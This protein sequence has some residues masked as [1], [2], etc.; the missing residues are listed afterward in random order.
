MFA[1]LNRAPR[2]EEAE[3]RGRERDRAVPVRPLRVG[4]ER[5]TLDVP[6]PLPERESVFDELVE[7]RLLRGSI[8][9]EER[10]V[11]AAAQHPAVAPDLVLDARI[12][13]HAAAIRARR[14]GQ[15][16][17]RSPELHLLEVEVISAE[18]VLR[19]E[20]IRLVR[21]VRGPSA[22]RGGVA[23][24]VDDAR[25]RQDGGVNAVVV[26]EPELGVGVNQRGSPT[27][28]R[29]CLR[30]NLVVAS[31]SRQCSGHAAGEIGLLEGDGP[32]PRV[33]GTKPQR[34]PS[35]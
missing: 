22:E 4:R 21:P 20:G 27:P 30:S 23:L 28:G 12:S 35:G 3:R 11:D 7:V 24:G 8:G 1:G 31:P 19:R 18:D 16:L 9:R 33:T 10:C 15:R 13:I 26:G 25:R 17:R 29:V 14:V 2:Q 34:R 32:G 6:L 5:G